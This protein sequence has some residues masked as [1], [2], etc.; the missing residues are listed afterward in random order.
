MELSIRY[1]PEQ[2]IIQFEN[3]PNNWL[4]LA[5]VN[6][7][8]EPTLLYRTH[9]Y[10]VVTNLCQYALCSDL[11]T[12]PVDHRTIVKLAQDYA[13]SVCGTSK[14]VIYT[15][16][17]V[18]NFATIIKY[19]NSARRS[20][21]EKEICRWVLSVADMPRTERNALLALV[22]ANL[23]RFECGSYIPS[24]FADIITKGLSPKSQS[25]THQM[26]NKYDIKYA[27]LCDGALSN[28]NIIL[29]KYVGEK[30]ITRIQLGRVQNYDIQAAT[31]F[32]EAFAKICGYAFE[33]RNLPHVITISIEEGEQFIRMF[34][35]SKL[36]VVPCTEKNDDF[37]S[38]T[39]KQTP[40]ATDIDSEAKKDRI[41]S[42]MVINTFPSMVAGKIAPSLNIN[43][44][45]ILI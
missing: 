34:E 31:E 3:T 19:D 9:D 36:M 28:F 5:Y 39:P 26:T 35:A 14:R 38:K 6:A 45:T 20:T 11:K 41:I 8:G 21:P 18:G 2:S 13:K 15:A 32:A 27:V 16:Q 40:P 12:V 1:N 37:I 43:A 24:A 30:I 10:Y 42:P 4:P 33:I 25:P 29:V 44:K 23:M 22:R 17:V 7:V